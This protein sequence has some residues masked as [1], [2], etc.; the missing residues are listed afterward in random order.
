M[1]LIL[2]GALGPQVTIADTQVESWSWW[3]RGLVVAA[4]VL[5]VGWAVWLGRAPVL[6]L[7][8][9]QRVLGAAP[10]MPAQ[11]VAR[12][13]KMR[14]I[15]RQVRP[16][17]QPVAV[18]GM[19]GVGKSTLAA[20][21]WR[22]QRRTPAEVWRVWRL[23]RRFRHGVTWLD[24][25]PGQDPV[26]LLA[27]LARRLGVE[28][29]G[30][31]TVKAGRDVL[32]AALRRRRVLMVVDNVWEPAP[33]QALLGLG[34]RCGLVFTTREK[35]IATTV[36][37]IS[38]EVDALSETQALELLSLWSGRR[39]SQLPAEARQVCARVGNLA[40]GVAMAGAMAAQ[41][42]SFADVLALLD[43]GLDRVRADLDPEYPY[44]SL[45]A[46]IEASLTSLSEEDQDRYARLAV[47]AGRGPFSRAA[48]ERLWGP[49]L[50]SAEVG[51]LLADL[52]NRSL[53][54]S[55][56][57]GWYVAHD[58]HYDVM[59]SR[60]G[61]KDSEA[62]AAAHAH[63]VEQYRHT[64]AG[65]WAD[66][67]ADPYL[68]SRLV[69]HLHAAGYAEEARTVLAD[70]AWIRAR[71][72]HDRLSGLLA[73]YGYADDVLSRQIARALRLSAKAITADPA[74]VPVQLASRLLGHPNV[75]VAGW[76]RTLDRSGQGL[77]PTGPYPALTPTTEPLLQTLTGHDGVVEAVAISADGTT[78]ITG[79]DDGSVRVWDLRNGSE[80]RILPTG[81]VQAVAMNADGTT[82][83]T[84]SDDGSVRVWDLR[85]GS[86]P[87]LQTL[88]GHDGAVE[89]VA[90]SADGTTAITGSDDGSVRVWD[91]RNGSEPRILTGY[92]YLVRAVAISA[93]GTTA[94]AGGK[95]VYVWDLH[96]G[97]EPRI[98][99]TGPVRTVAISADGTTVISGGK[100]V[101][102]W[103][104]RKGGEPRFLIGGKSSA[105]A[106]AISADGTTAISGSRDG[107]VQVWD[108][109]EGGK[110]R[111]LTGHDGA[112]E[113]VAVSADGTTAITGS[114][115]SSA[116]VWDLQSGEPCIPTR[117][118]A[119]VRAVAISTDGT[120]AI[121]GNRD[122]SVQVWDLREGGE[123]RVLTG[124]DG[125]ALAVAISADGTTAISGDD[126]GFVRLWDLQSGE[127]CVLT[128]LKGGL[129]AVAIS[130]D[131]TTAITESEDGSVRVWDLRNDSEPR[132]LTGRVGAVEAMAINADGTTAI[133]GSLNGSVQVWD[134]REGGEP[135]VLTGHDGAVKAVAISA[136]GTTAIS[137]GR[138]VYVWDLREGSEPHTLI[139]HS[140]VWTVA[141]S[142]D[143]TTAI[144]GSLN[145][146]VLV[147]DLAEERCIA[148]WV[149][150]YPIMG[151]DVVLG[152]SLRIGVG[153]SHGAP[154]M[155]ELR[156]TA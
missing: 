144:T 90:I 56:G 55:A 63:L 81:P 129:P 51:D 95:D 40:L 46:A 143:G 54:T 34:P 86:E 91:L 3:V 72:I 97:G 19:G 22:I 105:L 59:I 75:E 73:D 136:D 111:T 146:S 122:G 67:A 94:I 69:G 60:L 153:Q 80:P 77:W 139:R 114:R 156:S 115:D 25:N 65:V 48:A 135:R 137:G 119:A 142:A 32:A 5:L 9:G 87:L 141:I 24:V 44:R 82:A 20:G 62:L 45:L 117:R 106:V 107:S 149:G 131:G 113:A 148:S 41:D 23:R 147:W 101:Y 68:G 29:T 126:E 93:D 27:D 70:V 26:V 88:T 85:N 83:I 15:A 21:L 8:S 92:T 49:E 28:E 145:G 13:D 64:Y 78:A 89:A 74:L 37:A 53:L 140:M 30:F 42:R 84:G 125:A 14:Q 71:L 18:V 152:Q 109:H 36:G 50:S 79:S 31:T 100:G 17:G 116:R 118:A 103:D 4:G 98:L 52:M 150:D 138:D 96:N 11:L 104:L 39:V 132:T 123:P 47:F 58:L 16:G 57:E 120:T 35:H 128:K 1:T 154:Y 10:R 7:R 130:A 134:L 33:V 2:T 127:S 155:L 133:T 110:P 112:V 124:H 61:G 38:V 43:H 76:A 151:C 66:S 108:L 121:T 102:V 6:E 99:S 12:P